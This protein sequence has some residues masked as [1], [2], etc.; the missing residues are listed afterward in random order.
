MDAASA[1][2]GMAR[3]VQDK[4]LKESF[5]RPMVWDRSDPCRIIELLFKRGFL[6]EKGRYIHSTDA[7]KRSSIRCQKW[8]RD[9]T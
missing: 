3:F 5:V 8:R 7:G 1:M 9:R 2:T 6:T 4:D